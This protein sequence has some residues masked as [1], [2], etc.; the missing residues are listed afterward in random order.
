MARLAAGA[1]HA[2]FAEHDLLQPPHLIGAEGEG[3]FDAHF[4]PR[5]AI[6]IMAGGDHGDAGHIEREL[7][8]I[9]HRGERQA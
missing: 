2:L 9:G 8:E 3:G 5:P 4:H 1:R 7:R 6:F